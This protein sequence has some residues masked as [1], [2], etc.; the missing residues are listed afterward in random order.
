MIASLPE[1]QV[2]AYALPKRGIGIYCAKRKGYIQSLPDGERG[3]VRKD[4]GDI[5]DKEEGSM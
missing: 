3:Q 1:E 5:G 2:W 4:I